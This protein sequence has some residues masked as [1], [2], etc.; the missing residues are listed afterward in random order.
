MFI[1][2]VSLVTVAFWCCSAAWAP[3]IGNQGIVALLP[4]IVFFGTNILDKDDFNSFLW[5]VVM[6]AQVCFDNMH[7]C[8]LTPSS[9]HAA[10]SMEVP[11]SLDTVS[12]WHAGGAGAE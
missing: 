9:C 8:S 1:V 3:V 2:L 12:T 10:S 11:S 7:A 5:H 6:L 4:L